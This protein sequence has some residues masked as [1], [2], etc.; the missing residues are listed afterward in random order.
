[1]VSSG[2]QAS[3]AIQAQNILEKYDKL[4]E[5]VRVLRAKRQ[6]ELNDHMSYK[7]AYDDMTTW[8]RRAREKVPALKHRSL[9]DRLAIESA[10]QSLDA[11]L[12]KQGQGQM[13]VE[14][15][16]RCCEVVLASTS[17]SGQDTIR[18][19]VRTLNEAFETFFRE[20]VTQKQSLERTVVQWR[21][22][23]EE[24]ERLSDWLLQA[25]IEIKAQKNLMLSTYA[26]KAKQVETVKSLL[27]R[28]ESGKGQIDKFQSTAS[29]LLKSHLDTYISNHNSS[30]SQ[31]SDRRRINLLPKLS[32]C[33]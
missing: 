8:I 25:D 24:Y 16:N 11:L 32:S 10:V 19:E 29:D 18:N 1:M 26:E 15:L 14:A 17:G 33:L 21:D 27:E 31:E 3:A 13:K 4:S 9:G 20:I 5:S 30:M 6:H 12:N 22:Y 2:Q 23:K 28:L 7:E